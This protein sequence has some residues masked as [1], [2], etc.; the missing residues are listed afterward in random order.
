[1]RLIAWL[2]SLEEQRMRLDKP[3]CGPAIEEFKSPGKL[4]P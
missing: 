1:M 3:R 2:E 4:A